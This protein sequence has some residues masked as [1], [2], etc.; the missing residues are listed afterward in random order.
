MRSRRDRREKTSMAAGPTVGGSNLSKEKI[1]KLIQQTQKQMEKACQINESQ[2]KNGRPQ[3]DYKRC[4]LASAKKR[5]W[6]TIE[7]LGCKSYSFFTK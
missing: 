4:W 1:G 7:V 3:Q 2:F 5:D 6:E